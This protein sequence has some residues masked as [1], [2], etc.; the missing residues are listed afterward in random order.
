[1]LLILFLV[2]TI[3]ITTAQQIQHLKTPVPGDDLFTSPEVKAF[4]SYNFLTPD[5]YTGRLNVSIP[6]FEVK[7]GG[8]SVPISL[9]YNASGVKIDDYASNVGMGWNLNASGNVIRIIKDIEDNEIKEGSWAEPDPDYGNYTYSYISQKGFLKDCNDY[10][11]ENPQPRDNASA[12]WNNPCENRNM[13]I[14]ASP[15]F[16]LLNAPGISSKFYLDKVGS[17]YVVKDVMNNGYR[18]DNISRGLDNSFN[19]IGFHS[20]EVRGLENYNWNIGEWKTTAFDYQNFS[21]TNTNGIKYSFG[22][23]NDIIENISDYSTPVILSNLTISVI[24]STIDKYYYDILKS[25]WHLDQIEDPSSN[26]TVLFNYQEYQRTIADVQNHYTDDTTNPGFLNSAVYSNDYAVYGTVPDYFNSF[27]DLLDVDPNYFHTQKTRTKYS[28]LN[29]LQTITFDEGS[30]EFVYGLDRQDYLQDKALTEVIVRDFN[31]KIIK[32]VELLYSYF[33]S[34]ENCSQPECKRLKLDAVVYKNGADQELNRYELDYNDPND[35]PNVKSF[36]QD[37]LGYYN[38]NGATGTSLKTPTLYFHNNL[39]KYSISPIPL[40]GISSQTIPG[41]YS[42]SANSNSLKG[43]LKS[44]TYPTGGKSEFEYENHR[45]MLLG[46]EYTAGGARIKRQKIDNGE[47]HIV[48][49]DYIY[50]DV[51]DT[52]SSGYVNNLPAYGSILTR[53]RTN[54]QLTF[55]TYNESKFG[56]ELTE[57]AF[58]GYNRVIEKTVSENGEEN[59]YTVYEFTSPNEHP[60]IDESYEICE[61]MDFGGNCTTTDQNDVSFLVSNSSYPHLTYQDNDILRGRLVSKTVFDSDYKPLVKEESEY[62]YNTLETLELNYN[63]IM[64]TYQHYG[65]SE[66]I[67]LATFHKSHILTERNLQTKK[68]TTEYLEGGEKITEMFFEYDNDYPFLTKQRTIDDNGEISSENFYPFQPQV[69]YQPNISTLINQNR[70]SAPVLQIAKRDNIQISKSQINY[71]NFNGRVLPKSISVAKELNDSL[72]EEGEVV[73]VDEYGNAEEFLSKDGVYSFILWGY[74]KS[75][76][77]AL[78]KGATKNQVLQWYNNN[79]GENLIHI[80]SAS[81]ADDSEANENNLKSK[82]D[83]LRDAVGSNALIT[84]YTYDPFVGAKSMTDERGNTIYYEYDTHNRLK[85]IRDVDGNIVSE[86]NYNYKN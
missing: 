58:V 64:D 25:T 57:G 62:T 48:F 22:N 18:Y 50:R 40:T 19:N 72:I 54:N 60:N 41:D 44:I 1:M 63:R 17:N 73:S 7:S 27:L 56:L 55:L 85:Y 36:Q 68:V 2:S 75:L 66:P 59:G 16:F 37:F 29:R 80:Q 49:K 4:Q 6:I 9:S 46:H 33:I 74:K 28:R 12:D 69:S 34:N 30:V 61:S 52:N 8:I 39:G 47:G 67:N 5:L 81:D 23:A 51:G 83:D 32:K 24:P 78:V 70:I 31:N 82:L 86:N 38:N 53:N 79:T 84:T 21:V 77:I 14:D 45:F 26:K 13:K 10:T 3:Q 76:P 15:D 71:D 65:S 43:T 42:I 11:F 20:S 35:L